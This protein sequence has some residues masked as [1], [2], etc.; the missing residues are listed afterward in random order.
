MELGFFTVV[1]F[2]YRVIFAFVILF[3]A[4]ATAGTPLVLW[5]IREKWYYVFLYLLAPLVWALCYKLLWLI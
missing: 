4:L 1:S 5:Y 2:F 3:V